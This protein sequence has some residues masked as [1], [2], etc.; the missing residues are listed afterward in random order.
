MFDLY[1][2]DESKARLLAANSAE[3]GAWLNA[4]PVSSL[5]LR[6]SDEAIR[7]AVGLRVVA[8]LEQTHQCAFCGAEVNQFARHGLSCRFSQGRV[9]C[10]NAVNSIIHH[11][12]TAAKL[13]SQL[14]PSGLHR[15]DGRRPDGM[16]M[17]PRE[18]GRYL[19]WD[20]T[21]IDT[22][23]QSHCRRAAIESG[24]AAAHAE[25]EKYK[26]YAHLD[27]IY[28]FQP[29]AIETSGSIGPRSRT[30]PRYLGRRL[31]RVT[32]EPKSFAFLMQRISVAVQV[33]NATSVIGSLP[34]T[35][36]DNF[37]N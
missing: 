3:S 13:P 26:K 35:V 20:A 22:F 9:S 4:P 33:G 28:R 32:G 29:I 14:E 23:S 1:S 25:E 11:A 37:V 24:G 36:S 15:A 5:G 18:Q 16:T 7:I 34:V 17:V 12:L 2:D 27:S 6:M 31:K 8:P 10:H 19:V 30:F 21:C